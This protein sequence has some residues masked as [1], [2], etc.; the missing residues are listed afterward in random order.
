VGRERRHIRNP[1]SC[2]HHRG[3][4]APPCARGLSVRLFR[5]QRR[6]GRL[7][8][9]H[10]RFMASRGVVPRS[11]PARRK[12]E[13]SAGAGAG[14]VRTCHQSQN[15][16][17]ARADGAGHA[18]RHCR[19]GA[20]M[21]RREFMTLFGGAAVAWPLAAR[22]QQREKVRRIGVL[23]NNAADDPESQRRMTA[24]VQG[25]Q[26]LGWTDGRN[27]RIETR[28]G[29]GD[30]ER[31][32]KNAAELVALAPDV[33]VAEDSASL[34]PL[35]QLTRAIPVVFTI[36]PDQV[37]AGFV[38]SLSRPGGNATGFSQFEFGL[39]GK[40]LELL[41]EIAPNVTRAAVLREAG[42]TAGVAQF[43][44]LQAVAPSL[45]VELVPLNVRDGAQI[46]RSVAAFARSVT[47]GMIV[48]SSPLAAVH[49][50]LII[51]LAA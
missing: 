6:P 29:A 9:R 35:L 25:L 20:R 15:R 50:K 38:D 16:P 39:S 37:G 19:R 47:D 11:H 26:Q 2:G 8:L 32:R 17:G 24:F 13:R 43:A 46:E 28:W 1:Q 51:A 44:A 41:K 48:T 36:V 14:Q 22:A 45:A 42:L 3:G 21:R 12:T 23:L 10:N 30:A 40:W 34:G 18:A 31:L 33:V 49:R 27:V 5:R 7:W 4:G